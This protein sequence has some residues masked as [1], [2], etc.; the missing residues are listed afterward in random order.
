MVRIE[1]YLDFF[2]FKIVGI[3]LKFKIEVGLIRGK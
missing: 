1:L 3:V 2:V